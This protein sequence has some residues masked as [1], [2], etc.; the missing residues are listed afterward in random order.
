MLVEESLEVDGQDICADC[1]K[2]ECFV[3]DYCDEIHLNENKHYIEEQD[4]Y[5]CEEC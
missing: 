1:I 2:N 3:C 4:I 5:V